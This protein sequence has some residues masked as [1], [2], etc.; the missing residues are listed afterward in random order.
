MCSFLAHG[1]S[2]KEA[3]ENC[4]PLFRKNPQIQ[5][6]CFY[7]QCVEFILPEKEEVNADIHL[8]EIS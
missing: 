4:W 3:N 1:L 5:F 7:I 8:L 2:G 6:L